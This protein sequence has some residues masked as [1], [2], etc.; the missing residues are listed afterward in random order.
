MAVLLDGP[1]HGYGISKAIRERSGDA[2]K[3]GEGQLYP[4]L[5]E[6]EEAGQVVAEWEMQEGDPPRRVYALTEAG[7]KELAKRAAK[8]AEFTAAVGSVLSVAPRL[9]VSHE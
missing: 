6:L 7:K 2:L 4:I 1:S 5:H 9:E 3:L 8:W